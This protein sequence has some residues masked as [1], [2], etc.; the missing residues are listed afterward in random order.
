M[1]YDW[2]NYLHR[3]MNTMDKFIDIE[4]IIYDNPISRE[5]RF[6]N[7]ASHTSNDIFY[8]DCLLPEVV[9]LNRTKV[10]KW[11]DGSL[12][13]EDFPFSTLKHVNIKLQ[14]AFD[15][16]SWT[17]AVQ[18]AEKLLPFL[19]K[20]L[21]ERNLDTELCETLDIC[22]DT[23]KNFFDLNVVKNKVLTNFQK[24]NMKMNEQ[25]NNNFSSI[26]SNHF[27]FPQLFKEIDFS[28]KHKSH[29]YVVLEKVLH[30]FDLLSKYKVTEVYL[31]IKKI[32]EYLYNHLK[33]I[34]FSQDFSM[35]DIESETLS[36]LS[37]INTYL[38]MELDKY[39]E[40]CI[41]E[42]VSI[43]NNIEQTFVRQ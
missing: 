38:T 39:L 35:I 4:K 36:I 15:K 42:Q 6:T 40:K 25:Q 28:N 7:I 43:M 11:K 37:K 19:E 34:Y 21:I 8:F 27:K 16:Y 17:Q 14:P 12:S 2:S 1:C 10:L 41:D 24:R 32:D 9:L 33:N 29:I 23:I 13:T 30:N 31:Q 3:Q 26:Y 18:K 20:L 5:L 22:I